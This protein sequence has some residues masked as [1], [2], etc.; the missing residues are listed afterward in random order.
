M[1]RLALK[2]KQQ[3][4]EKIRIESLESWIKRS[5]PT[6][7]Y[8]RCWLCGRSRSYMREFGICR[9]CFRKYAREWLIMGVKK[10][11]W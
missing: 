10:S 11:S 8:N 9:I 1:T 4:L 6:R 3:K 2:V 5:F 7:H